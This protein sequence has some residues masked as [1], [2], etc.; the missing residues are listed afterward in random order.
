MAI[1][2]FEIREAELAKGGG[3]NSAC[4]PLAVAFAVLG[5]FKGWRRRRRISATHK[6]KE[7]KRWLMQHGKTG[8]GFNSFLKV[9]L[10]PQDAKTSC[11]FT[12]WDLHRPPFKVL[13]SSGKYQIPLLRKGVVRG[14]MIILF[15]NYLK[16]AILIFKYFLRKIIFELIVDCANW[17]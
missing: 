13:C 1:T 5:F 17:P 12:F 8:H 2:E 10:G 6:G 9:S 3:G 14:K 4:V 7:K 16:S 11:R 15:S